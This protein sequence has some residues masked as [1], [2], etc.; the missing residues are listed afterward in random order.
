MMRHYISSRNTRHCHSTRCKSLKH[1]QCNSED[2]KATHSMH[3]THGTNKHSIAV[4]VARKSDIVYWLNSPLKIVY[5]L[6]CSNTEQRRAKQRALKTLGIAPWKGTVICRTMF[7]KIRIH[8]IVSSL[9]L[10][11]KTLWI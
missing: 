11:H 3:I 2:L 5:R 10:D 4:E 9:C 8:C 1:G 7:P 6:P